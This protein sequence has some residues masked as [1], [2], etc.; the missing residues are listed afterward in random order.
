MSINMGKLHPHTFSAL[1]RLSSERQW[2]EIFRWMEP[3]TVAWLTY[4]LE[5]V[6]DQQENFPGG[7][8]A[9]INCLQA[10]L[11]DIAQTEAKEAKA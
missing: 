3:E 8:W 11:R 6:P 5:F 9:T 1:E 2:P 4:R 10:M 7:K